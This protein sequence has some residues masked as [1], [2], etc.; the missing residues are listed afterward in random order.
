MPRS[1]KL[2]CYLRMV[3]NQTGW[4]KQKQLG[5]LTIRETMPWAPPNDRLSEQNKKYVHTLIL[6]ITIHICRH[7]IESNR[8]EWN[9]YS[10]T[11]KM[12]SK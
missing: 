6:D 4:G 12:G 10:C 2:S 7:R 8:F 11:T 1:E 9:K 5:F 3:A